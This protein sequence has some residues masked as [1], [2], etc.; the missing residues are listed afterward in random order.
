MRARPVETLEEGDIFF[1]YRPR[2]AVTE[3]HD[4]TDVQRFYV[5][6]AA[7]RPR[8]VYRLLVVGRKQLPSLTAGQHPERRNWALIVRVSRTADEIR[9]ELEAYEYETQT[10]GKRLV[11][12]AKPLGEGRYQL[13]RHRRHTELAYVLE[14]PKHAGPAQEEFEIQEEASY[15]LGVKNP[16][17]TL[18]GA[19]SPPRPPDYPPHLREKFGARRWI[20]AEPGLLDHENTQLVFLAAHIGDVEDELG[21]HIPTEDETLATAEV[22]RELRV[23]CEREAVTPLL[24][25]TFPH[26]E[27]TDANA[28]EGGRRTTTARYVCE[29]DGE[30]FDQKSRYERHMASAHPPRAVNAADLEHALA[31]IDLPK[32]KTGLVEHAA[33]RLPPD[34]AILRAIREL[35]ARTYRTAADIAKAFGELKARRRH[36]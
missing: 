21:V 32:T 36:P 22:C 15:V 31:G 33:S 26:E 25:G 12:A 19:P 4:R 2:V 17:V 11:A 35:P 13:L 27:A 14:L 6:L 8:K 7:K 30:T 1:F 18:P 5:V 3:V 29:Y 9:G 16:E 34:S 28:H 20:E 10:R 23:S 24:E